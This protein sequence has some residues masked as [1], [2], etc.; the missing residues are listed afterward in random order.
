MSNCSVLQHLLYNMLFAVINRKNHK[1]KCQIPELTTNCS[2][3]MTISCETV[4]VD[5]AD[6]GQC[7]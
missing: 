3:S 4:S 5:C 2:G 6:P 7:V 1:H